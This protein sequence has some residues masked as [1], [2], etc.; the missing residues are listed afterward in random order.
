LH[1]G[2]AVVEQAT[3]DGSQTAASRYLGREDVRG[4][5]PAIPIS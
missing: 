3:V 1:V 4:S 2:L 5:V